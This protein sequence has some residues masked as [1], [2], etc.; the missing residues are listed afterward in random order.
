MKCSG[1][2]YNSANLPGQRA[3]H[4]AKKD[5]GVAAKTECSANAVMS[6]IDALLK[7]VKMIH[8][9]SNHLQYTLR[10]PQ[11]VYIVSKPLQKMFFTLKMELK[12]QPRRV[13]ITSRIW[14]LR[15][16]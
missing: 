14:L 4:K 2:I 12:L 9:Q 8:F 3:W 6:G 13:S 1:G 15:I 7:T 10:C 5:R 16:L 11:K